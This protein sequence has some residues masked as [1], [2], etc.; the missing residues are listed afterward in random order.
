[1]WEQIRSN[2]RRSALLVAAMAGLLLCVG[3]A[4][5][6]ALGQGLG[7]MG[8]AVA[9]AVWLAQSAVSYFAGDRIFLALS[10]ARRITHADHPVLFNVVEEMQIAAGLPQTPAVYLIDEE[11]PNAFATG[12]S[13]EKASI[14]VTSGLLKQLSRD[15]LQGVIGHEIGHIVNRDMLYM[16]MVSIMMGSVVLLADLGLRALWGGS[17]RS[18]TSREAEKAQF[19]F[20]IVALALIALA[21]LA[22]R[23]IYFAV[24]RRREYLADASGAQF[25]RNPEGL[26][27]ALEKMSRATEPLRSASRATAALYIVNPLKASKMGLA[28]VTSTHPPISERIKIL[29]SMAGAGLDSYDRAFCKVTGRPVG[30]VPFSALGQSPNLPA[31][32]PA[33]KPSASEEVSRARKTTDLLWQLNDYLFV[34]CA[35]GTKLKIPPSYRG[36]SLACPHCTTIHALPHGPEKRKA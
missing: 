17:G 20:L 6:E 9:F 26:A 4:L 24:S 35:C 5:G 21:P 8:L 15:E 33:P 14:A 13:P 27:G 32:K 11:S 22:A 31:A 28:D 2:E 36:H 34:S 29:R 18:R 19:L 3:Y 23:L 10:R 7:P 1:M 30:V 12:R 16:M 25:T